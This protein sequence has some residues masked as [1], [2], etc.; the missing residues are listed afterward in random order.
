VKHRF[1]FGVSMRVVRP[2][3]VSALR[4]ATA[5]LQNLAEFRRAWPFPSSP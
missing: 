2:K 3:A 1:R 5:L 4:F